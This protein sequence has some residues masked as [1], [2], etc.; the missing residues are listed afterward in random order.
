MRQDLHFPDSSC[1]VKS[2]S[3]VKHVT[4]FQ[5][6]ASLLFNAQSGTECSITSWHVGRHTGSSAIMSSM[7]CLAP[8]EHARNLHAVHPHVAG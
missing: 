4:E 5:M 3:I 8:G 6:Y 2:L 7:S 1:Y